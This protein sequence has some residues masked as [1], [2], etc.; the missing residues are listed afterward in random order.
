MRGIEM[1]QMGRMRA[2]Q[3]MEVGEASMM[4]EMRRMGLV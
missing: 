2:E 3:R 4:R 1:Q